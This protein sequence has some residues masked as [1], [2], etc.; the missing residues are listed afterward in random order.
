MEI[1]LGNQQLSNEV[2]IIELIDLTILVL[3]I[4]SMGMVYV[5]IDSGDF[6]GKC[7]CIRRSYGLQTSDIPDC[8]NLIG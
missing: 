1:Y 5:Y 3:P 4:G 8:L 2:L 6:C 7:Q